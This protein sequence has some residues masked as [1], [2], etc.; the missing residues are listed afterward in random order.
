[1]G[2][3]S[4]LI[5]ILLLVDMCTCSISGQNQNLKMIYLDDFF[6]FMKYNVNKFYGAVVGD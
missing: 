6:W 3:I 5:S 1:M 2:S 4:G